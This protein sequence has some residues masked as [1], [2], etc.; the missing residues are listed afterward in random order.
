MQVNFRREVRQ[1]ASEV[2]R[3]CWQDERGHSVAATVHSFDVSNHGAGVECPSELA[4]GTVAYLGG[5][6]SGIEGYCTVRYCR[7]YGYAFRLG[8][9]FHDET[10]RPRSEETAPETDYYEF[11]QISPKAE[12]ATID[13]IYKFMAARLHPDNPETGDA[14]RFLLLNRAYEVLSDPDR[15]AEYDET[16]QRPEAR[17]NPIF[18]TRDF[19]HGIEGEANRRLGIL[20]LLYNRRRSHAEHPGFSLFEIEKEMGFPREYLDF[21]A[22]YLRSKQY[23]TMGDNA[24]LAITALGIDYVEGNV[25]QIPLLQK[26]LMSGP[27]TTTGPESHTYSKSGEPPLQLTAGSNDISTKS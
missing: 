15:R 6:D 24:E 1:R 4:P 17:P 14:E 20:S 2:Y 11:L 9:E 21:A 5:V 27:K 8:L 7:P 13:R 26:L 16:Y 10:R 22:W 25:N 3:L 12:F 19:L 18:G 23:V